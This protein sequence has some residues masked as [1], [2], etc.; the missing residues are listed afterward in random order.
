MNTNASTVPAHDHG[1]GA[2]SEHVMSVKSL[3]TIFGLL[4][5]LMALT[6]IMAFIDLGPLGVPVAMAI[7][8]A[9]AVLILLY[10]MHVKFSDKLVWVFSGAAFYWLL[11]LFFQSLFDYLTRGWLTVLGK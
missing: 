10:F 8:T 7:A 2:E 4:L 3:V 5:G 11:I 1:P 9:K 6:V